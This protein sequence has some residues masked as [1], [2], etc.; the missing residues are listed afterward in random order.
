MNGIELFRLGRRLTKVGVRS[1]PESE[2]KALNTSVRMVMVE[3]FEHP[4][5]TIGQIVERTGF[6]QSHVSASV[7][8]LREIGML[9]TKDDPNDGRRTLVAPA[10]SA[11]HRDARLRAVHAPIHD[12]LLAE[13]TAIHG[14]ADA[15]RVAEAIAALETLNR[16]FT[17]PRTATPCPATPC[18]VTPCPVTPY[19]F[20]PQLATTNTTMTPGTTC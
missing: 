3:V 8:R 10:E 6:P 1:F 13:L 15:S 18:P 5:S 17:P 16:L 2:F 7:A 4:D 19:Q 11:S 9:V 12:E 20:T 14:S